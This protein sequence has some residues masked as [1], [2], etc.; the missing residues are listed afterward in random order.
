MIAASQDPEIV[1]PQL[2]KHMA[3]EAFADRTMLLL[4][5]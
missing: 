3:R 1:I 2:F 4:L 5:L